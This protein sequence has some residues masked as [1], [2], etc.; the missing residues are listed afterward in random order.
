MLTSDPIPV[1]RDS[2]VVDTITVPIYESVSEA[3][4][5]QG[6]DKILARLNAQIKT[7]LVNTAR[8]ASLPKTSGKALRDKAYVSVAS[9][10]T[11]ELIA[12]DG[13]DAKITALIDD[14]FENLKADAAENLQAIEAAEA[15]DVAA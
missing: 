8:A 10:R 13:D 9:T 12:C 1:R 6:E 14:E 7:D 11:D 15:A 4:E 3:C 5:E 2:K